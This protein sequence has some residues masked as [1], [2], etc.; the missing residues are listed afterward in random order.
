MVH[1]GDVH[2]DS[3]QR[4]CDEELHQRLCWVI[5]GSLLFGGPSQKS[6]GDVRMEGIVDNFL[7]RGWCRRSSLASGKL[8]GQSI[9]L[10][11]IVFYTST[12]DTVG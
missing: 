1:T 10:S 9:R 5:E 7:C 6:A 12:A 8:A 11:T 2:R 4:G 3:S